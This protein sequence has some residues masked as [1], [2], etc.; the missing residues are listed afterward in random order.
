MTLLKNPSFDGGWT[1]QTHTGQEWGEI[2]TPEGWVA[3]W[4]EG[5]P[6]PNDSTNKLG[7]GRYEMQVIG[8]A[9]P[10]KSPPRL[11]TTGDGNR[12]LKFFTFFRVHDG[13]VYQKVT[14]LHAGDKCEFSGW[15]HAWSSNKDD[16]RVSDG[17]HVGNRAF[18]AV[19]GTP[20]LD[21]GDRNFTFYVGID[22]T[23]GTDPWGDSVVW[24]QGAHIY[25]AF[26]QIPA[27]KVT[28]QASSITVFIRSKVLW[29]FKHCDVYL[30][31]MD[32]TVTPAVEG[33]VPDPDP[34][35]GGEGYDYPVIAKGSK[36]GVHTIDLADT[37]DL[38][39]QAPISTVKALEPGALVDVKDLCENTITV[40]RYMHGVIGSVNVE[41][42]DINGD[43]NAEARRVADSLLPLWRD[44]ELREHVDYWEVTNEL[45]PV[46][47]D[48]HR[49]FAEFFKF[50]MEIVEKEGFKIL[51]FSY[52]L[53]VPEWEEWE[54]VV[55]TGVFA[56]A[57]AGGHGLAL[58]EYAFPVDQFWG[59]PLPGH[60]TYPNRG[61]L[62]GRY[63]HL[64]R[65]FL[66]PRDE[67]IPLFI[68]EMNLALGN[69]DNEGL[70]LISGQE[71]IKQISWYD[72]LL[73]EDY[74]VIGAHLFTLTNVP[75]W[76]EY[77][78]SRFF[79]QLITYINGIKD[80]PNALPPSVVPEPE[81]DIVAP[82]VKYDRTY[83]LLP[84][85]A[86]SDWFKAVGDSGVWDEWRT[87]VGG[88]AD[89]AG[90]GLKDYRSIIIVN[91]EAWAD[92]IFA[93]FDTYYPGADVRSIT[94]ETPQALV[95]ALHGL[96][97]GPAAQVVAPFSQR[98]PRWSS[99][100]LGKSSTTVYNNG[101]LLVGLSSICTLLDASM[102]PLELVTW[103]NANNGFLDDG[104]MVLTKP[105]EYI[106]GLKF[107]A[108]PTWRSAGQTADLSMVEAALAR[109]PVLVQVDFNP[110]DSDLDSH[111]VVATGRIGDDLWVMDPWTGEMN[112]LMQTY[113]RGTLAQSI[114]AMLDYRLD[115]IPTPPPVATLPMIG[116]NDH[117]GVGGGAAKL[118][119]ENG[120]GFLVQP[121]FIG[122]S[123]AMINAAAAQSA[124]VKLVVRLCYSWSTDKGGAGALPL[125]G[126]PEWQV[127][128]DA[129][130][131][132]IN[133]SSGVWGWEI[134]NECN[135]PRESPL[136]GPLTP[137]SVIETY[138]Y[139]SVR[140]TQS[141]LTT[142]ALD[143][144]NALLGDPQDWAK[145]VYGGI[146]RADF[147]SV[148]GY[149]R[150]PDPAL[151]GSTAKFTDAP[152]LWQSLNYPGC[153]TDLLA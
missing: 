105:Q 82:R 97:H 101:C 61:S 125:F 110:A 26:S 136:A 8:W 102:D 57:K 85:N 115:A 2:F 18:S 98:D 81:S 104:R 108:Y 141:R 73:R 144:F 12:S 54:A 153:C 145:S 27:V 71:W 35:P 96:V 6:V 84:P 111:W 137:Q 128:V 66:I 19:E 11:H 130:V 14:G 58:H 139:I 3:F 60:P 93:F 7:Y 17:S 149:V 48:G 25:N 67:V 86:G 109:G 116:F 49:R 39:I 100:K 5:P 62:C 121:L 69:G 143:P 68:T 15:A 123:P 131:Q 4:K 33:P 88:S 13:G 103:M 79:P 29:P 113:S 45:D 70:N 21:D 140:C 90:F 28:A 43:L 129:A 44:Q 119:I 52:S 56:K 30:D 83:V 118:L 127:F 78:Y 146:V 114:F 16:P 122:G 147:I 42:P 95:L 124:G 20:G 53:G 133:Q 74:Y 92:D 24:G 38:M 47:V 40:G 63:R 59:E 41:G 72:S 134:G 132:T 148:H 65:D 46:G 34:L 107:V 76:E 75:A 150:G 89:D 138:N 152:L 87:T 94:A 135:N 106:S 80:E 36:M 10:F 9:D 23:G 126:S 77:D 37:L 112:M 64:Y 99:I 31:D 120:G 91:P 142:G 50:L 55:A 1:R 151:V 22:P 117:E 32:L 51:L